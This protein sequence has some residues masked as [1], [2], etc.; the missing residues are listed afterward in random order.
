MTVEE[1]EF[2]IEFR[3]KAHTSEI[4]F[5][6]VSA[7]EMEAVIY[8]NDGDLEGMLADLEEIG[9]NDNAVERI[10]MDIHIDG[11]EIGTLEVY[12]IDE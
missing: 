3:P 12:D 4:L 7:A 8:D 1:P 5:P 11:Y 6:N 2:D 10:E 9:E